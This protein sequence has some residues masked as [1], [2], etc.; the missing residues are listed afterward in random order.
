[1]SA[2]NE[3]CWP[4]GQECETMKEKIQEEMRSRWNRSSLNELKKRTLEI[5]EAR[6]NNIKPS[7][8]S[9]F[10]LE[11]NGWENVVINLGDGRRSISFGSKDGESKIHF[12]ESFQQDREC[13]LLK[14]IDG[15]VQDNK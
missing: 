6:A 13:I 14:V 4:V 7:C 8:G 11:I 3:K 5:R 2:N 1:M 9:V 12:S 10:S 15:E